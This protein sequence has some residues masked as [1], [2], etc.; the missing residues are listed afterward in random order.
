MNGSLVDVN[1][2][3]TA[4]IEDLKDSINE[5]LCIPSSRQR[6]LFR[7]RQLDD[8]NRTLESYGINSDNCKLHLVV[9]RLRRCMSILVK[10]MWGN[11]FEVLL[12][13]T[14]T[15]KDVKMKIRESE[16]IEVQH[17][18]LV[19]HGIIL[20]NDETLDSIGIKDYEKLFVIN[21][22]PDDS[23]SVDEETE[24]ETDQD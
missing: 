19:Y 17:Q 24:S 14:D 9:G 10:I 2:S 15:I 3:P 11:S 6:I 23:D 7:S 16:G 12:H 4:S 13:S 20:K 5:K 22:A 21:N 1:M 18:K 8:G